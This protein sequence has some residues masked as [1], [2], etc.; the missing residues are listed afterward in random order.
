MA[1]A[2][3]PADVSFGGM[4]ARV[5]NM[6]LGVWLVLSAYLWRHSAPMLVNAVLVGSLV[7]AF[8]ILAAQGLTWARHLNTAVAIWL[9]VSALFLPRLSTASVVN[10]LIVA[11]A[12]L[13]FSL[14]PTV[15]ARRLRISGH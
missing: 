13:L 1:L 9:F 2:L 3:S 7:V 5:S 12:I 14:M 6:V 8:A 11:L 15:R 4:S 10:H